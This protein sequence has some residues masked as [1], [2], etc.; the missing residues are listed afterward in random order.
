MVRIGKRKALRVVAGLRSQYLTSAT[1][2][3]GLKHSQEGL[4]LLKAI[5]AEIEMLDN[6][7]ELIPY[8]LA[9]Y[10]RLGVLIDYREYFSAVQLTL[11]CARDLFQELTHG[12]V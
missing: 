4:V 7:L 9:C 2:V 8:I 3:F 10:D 12:V 1:L 11:L 6:Q 5:S